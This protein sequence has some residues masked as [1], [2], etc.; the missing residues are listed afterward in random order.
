MRYRTFK[1]I[2]ENVSL[3][4]IGAMRF[5]ETTNGE[6]D[7]TAAIRIIRAAIDSGINYVDTAFTYHGEKS[8]IVVGKALKN[9]YRE[10]VLLADKMPIWLAKDEVHMRELFN[11][12]MKRLDVDCIDMY[13]IHSV[14][15]DNRK[16]AKE[17]KLLTFLEEMRAAGKIRYIGFSFHDSYELFQEVLDA[18]TWDFCQIQLNFMD[19]EL[20]AG[21]KGLQLASEKDLGV[22]IME[23]LKG[24]RLTSNIPPDIQ[25]IWDSA[26][27]RRPPAEWSFKWLAAMPEVTLILSGMSSEEQ[28]YENIKIMDSDDLEKLTDEDHILIDRIS[29]E[30]NRLVKYSCT[31]CEYCLPCPQGLNIPELLEYFNDWNTFGKNESTKTE[32]LQWVPED[33]F[34]SGCIGC[35]ACEKKCPQQLP[36]VQALKDTVAAFGK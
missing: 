33:G 12:Q 24:G 14:S 32:Y 9:G 17:L 15:Q 18:Y 6:V 5:P 30:Y 36:I 10:R 25:S 20:Q 26:D 19:K 29:S 21:V 35:G 31:G 3:L 11:I 7:E 27:V 22:I 34:A 4:G 16:R 28:V 13:L 8:E 23:P 1:K 2:N